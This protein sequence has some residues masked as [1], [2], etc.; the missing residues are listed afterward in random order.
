MTYKLFIK[1]N[2]PFQTFLPYIIFIF[3]L[4]NLIRLYFRTTNLFVQKADILSGNVIQT[5]N[6][7]EFALE[8]GEVKCVF[9]WPC[10]V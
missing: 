6:I 3:T 9:H 5:L 7:S 10:C 8:L 1:G 4:L 2:E